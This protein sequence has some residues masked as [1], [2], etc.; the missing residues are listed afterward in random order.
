MRA[1]AKRAQDPSNARSYQQ[2]AEGWE[3]MA[4][5]AERVGTGSSRAFPP[6]AGPKGEE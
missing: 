4:D 5:E 6:L 3:A 1:R 2:I